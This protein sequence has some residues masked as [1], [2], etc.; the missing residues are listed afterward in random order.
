MTRGE[1]CGRSSSITS[2][3]N[4]MN[5]TNRSTFT[6]YILC[7]L[8]PSWIIKVWSH[9]VLQRMSVDGDD[10]DGSGPLVVLFVEVLVEAGMVEQ[11]ERV[12]GV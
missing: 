4:E 3:D 1:T 8:F 9:H 7:F 11:P 5:S 10:S 6:F 12:K 2:Q